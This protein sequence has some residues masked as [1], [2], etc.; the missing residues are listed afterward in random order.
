MTAQGNVC[1]SIEQLPT[2]AIITTGLQKRGNVAMASGGIGDIWRG[3]YHEK[4]VTIKAF[5]IHPAGDLKEAKEVRIQ[6][7][8]ETPS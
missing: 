2:S 3:E 6:S 5:R 7:A 4:Q 1:S 8:W